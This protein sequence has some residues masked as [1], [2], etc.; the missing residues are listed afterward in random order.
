MSLLRSH[1]CKFIAGVLIIFVISPLPALFITH[2]YSYL[3]GFVSIFHNLAQ[4]SSISIPTIDW[5]HEPI[6]FS[7][8][9]LVHTSNHS[10]PLFPYIWE[11]YFLSIVR[12]TF[13]LVIGFFISLGIGHLFL[14]APNSLKKCSS[15]F[16]W[17]PYSFGTV[18][19]QCS[20]LLSLLY[21]SKFIKFPFFS[22]FII[23]CST[24]MI[25]VMQAIRKWLPF[26]N[27]TN[28]YEIKNSSFLVDTLFIALTSNH[29]SI[30]SSI[31]LSF[32]FMECIFHTNGLL[33]FIVQFG[34]NAPIVV[35]IGLLLLYIPYSILSFL[36]ALWTTNHSKQNTYTLTRSI[37]KP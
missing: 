34:R 13:T 31:I 29:K 19:L 36:Q 20:V 30:L 37:S 8:N 32:V 33:Q 22:S 7:A 17:I 21:I 28:E 3:T 23:V 1:I 14:K 9:Q 10:S 18:I 35:T 27:T 5:M 12:F 25:I 24:S 4:P 16:R 2:N 26:L 15:L 11:I 6:L